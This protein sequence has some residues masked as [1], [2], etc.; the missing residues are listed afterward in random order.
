M[1]KEENLGFLGSEEQAKLIKALIEDNKV[2][3]ELYPSLDQN[4]FNGEPIYRQIVGKMMDYYKQKGIIPTYSTLKILLRDGNTD[5]LT[6]EYIDSIKSLDMVDIDAILDVATVFF[7]QQKAIKLCNT[8]LDA[9][10]KNGYKDSTLINYTKKLEDVVLSKQDCSVTNP[11]E[12]VAEVLEGKPGE[13][14]PTGISFI[15]DILIGGL[16]KGRLGMIQ[17][18]A[19]CGK[20]TISTT[21]ANNAASKGYKV[22][23][24]FFEDKVEDIARKHYTCMTDGHHINDFVNAKDKEQL[25]NEILDSEKSE[26]IR[27]NLRMIKLP[28]GE[29]TVEDIESEYRKLMNS[30][31]FVPDVVFIDYFDCL[32]K[33]RDKIKSVLEAE[34]SCMRKLESFADKNKLALWIMQQGNRLGETSSSGGSNIQ[35][36]YTKKQIAHVYVTISRIENQQEQNLATVKVEKN[37]QGGVKTFENIHFDNGCMRISNETIVQALGD[38]NM[39]FDRNMNYGG[40]GRINPNVYGNSKMKDGEYSF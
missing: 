18:N 17:A 30:E 20:T 5:C 6:D 36:S 22:L 14:I 31:G 27:N 40:N 3:T 13:R 4:L 12:I 8:M 33:T 28:T 26:S 39:Y 29:K 7:K 32:K 38:G 35:G 11:M 23:Q 19:G 2:F 34:E 1:A 15:D 25:S 24:I 37:R 16:E 10:K 9:I 21:M